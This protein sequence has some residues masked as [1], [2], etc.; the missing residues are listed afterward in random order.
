MGDSASHLR[1]QAERCRR[2]ARES[3]D[4]EVAERLTNM[5]EEFERAAAAEHDP[6]TTAE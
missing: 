5:A 4:R 2:L 6:S 1:E 3:T